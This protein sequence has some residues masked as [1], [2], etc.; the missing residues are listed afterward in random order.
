M[1]G[2]AVMNVEFKY[3]FNKNM[4]Y[5]LNPFTTAI[6]TMADKLCSIAR[7]TGRLISMNKTKA[8]EFIELPD[9]EYEAVVHNNNNNTT[10]LSDLINNMQSDNLNVL[11]TGLGGCGKS[12]SLISVA[13]QILK[14]YMTAIADN[15][16]TKVGAIPVY[17]PL[18]SLLSDASGIEDYIIKQLADCQF[19]SYE[20]AENQLREWK[21]SFADNKNSQYIL[22]MLD[23][24]NEIVSSEQQSKILTDIQRLQ[25]NNAYR[26]IITSRYNLSNTFSSSMGT[27]TTK[28]VSFKMNDLEDNIVISHVKKCLTEKGKTENKLNII[29]KKNKLMDKKGKIKD[30]YCKPMGLVMFC[31]VHSKLSETED[32]LSQINTLGELLH[33]F[34][35]CIKNAYNSDDTEIYEKFLCYFGYRMNI[36]GVFTVKEADF[37]RYC[38]DF[39]NKYNYNNITYDDIKNNRL[40]NDVTKCQDLGVSQISFNHQNYRDYFAASFLKKIINSGNVEEI[41]EKT[42][43]DKK[44]PYEVLK[45]L[46]ELIGEYKYVNV[47]RSKNNKGIQGILNTI[48]NQLKNY[49]VALLIKIAVIGRNTDLS[50]FTFKNLDLTCTQLNNVVLFRK[51]ENAHICAEFDKCIISKSTFAPT[52]HAGAP[53]AILYLENRYILTFAKNGICCLDL[54]TGFSKMVADYGSDAILSAVSIPNSRKIVTGDAKGKLVL[55]E[56]IT[57]NKNNDFKLFKKDKY[58]INDKVY[59]NADENR[60]KET[61][62]HDIVLLNDKIIFSLKSGD[63]FS[64]AYNLKNISKIIDLHEYQDSSCKYCR[65]EVIGNDLYVSYGR[66]IFKYNNDYCFQIHDT[67]Y[68]GGYIYDISRIEDNGYSVLL[69]NYRDKKINDAKYSI[70]YM[71]DFIND[72]IREL[73]TIEHTTT[74]QGFKG[75]NKFS[76]PFNNGSA[77]YLTA[78]INDNIEEAGLYLF[79]FE[80]VWDNEKEEYICLKC[81]K[82]AE[83]CF[84][85]RHIM[86]IERALHFEYNGREYVATT[87][88]DRCVEILDIT[89]TEANLIYHIEGHT[90]GVTCMDVIDENTIYTSHYSGE[91]CKWTSKNGCWKCKTIAKPHSNEWVWVI[92]HTK[93]A[94]TDYMIASSYDHNISITDA[95]SGKFEILKGCKGRVK[96]FDFLNNNSIVAAYDYK[97][98]DKDNFSVHVFKNID[99]TTGIAESTVIYDSPAYVQCMCTDTDNLYLVVNQYSRI[100]VYRINKNKLINDNMSIFDDLH[101][102]IGQSDSSRNNSKMR[103]IDVIEI[104]KDKKLFA[105]GG[106][107]DTLYA[108]VW[109]E[110][111]KK[112]VIDSRP[113]S[114]TE[115]NRRYDSEDGISSI[116]LVKYN[117]T[118]YLIL[119][120]YDF[121]LYTYSI[122]ID[123]DEISLKYLSAVNNNGKILDV[124]YIE[125]TVYVS[126]LSGEVITYNINSLINNSDTKPA[127]LF[128]ASTGMHIVNVNLTN[129]TKTADISEDFK[130]IINY[131]GRI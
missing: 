29:I 56:Y 104:Y 17:I 110:N 75:W 115:T 55:W 3:N 43:I 8:E 13:T 105:C 66:K 2:S 50:M 74:S 47:P 38:T 54:K 34:M 93:L 109:T 42:G 101:H 118:I 107:I 9:L 129:C 16:D 125:N 116:K 5:L 97:T 117:G 58:I 73:K 131:Y 72:D 25:C 36:D 106:D 48:G 33:A 89:G 120:S 31:A 35:F 37:E 77:V 10:K 114:I 111:G 130:K 24:W 23:G 1:R 6:V 83:E 49:A 84:G 59:L 95:K 27:A 32:F 39:I 69:I 63:V 86:S 98:D 94:D 12:F 67:D 76:E 108:E 21:K 14:P 113:T 64:I 112:A 41:N 87:S 96:A 57:G 4:F 30:I 45:I 92:K 65:L 103:S 99:F 40:V 70:V 82:N 11:I 15:T 81:V 88:I 80:A 60:R 127:V 121:Y 7:D 128:Q 79:S 91:V 71:F 122:L 62:V 123:N 78:N 119:G 46:S 90:D 102:K 18:N 20:T 51:E 61:A 28:F 19:V 22:L 126:L 68:S 44:I 85:N 124:Q 53:Q 26:M 100:N 52:G